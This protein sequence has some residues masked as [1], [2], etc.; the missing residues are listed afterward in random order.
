M[1][2]LNDSISEFQYINGRKKDSYMLIGDNTF[3]SNINEESKEALG[4]NMMTG[5]SRTS[6]FSRLSNQRQSP[7]I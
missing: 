6:D 4:G 2:K 7:Y 1:E 5:R 3:K